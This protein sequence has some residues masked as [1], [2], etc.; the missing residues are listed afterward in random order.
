MTDKELLTKKFILVGMDDTKISTKE[1]PIIGTQALATCIGV[2]LYDEENK[3]AIVAHISSE[4]IP[5]IDKIFNLIMKNK[6]YN[7]KLKYKIITGYYEGRPDIKKILEAHFKDFIPL[8]ETLI[9]SNAV[10]T[11][12][13]IPSRQFAFDAS[14]GKFVSD[15]VLFGTEYYIINPDSYNDSY[16]KHR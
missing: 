16:N 14:S 12:D 3:V 15:K 11:D 4:P 9:T 7:N 1:K 6:L 13:K 2:L 10:I 5:I 8:E